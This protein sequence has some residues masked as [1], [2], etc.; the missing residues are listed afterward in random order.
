MAPCD[1]CTHVNTSLV[2][3]PD[4]DFLNDIMAVVQFND[5][6]FQLIITLGAL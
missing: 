2:P 4:L 3:T 5:R 1:G 6:H